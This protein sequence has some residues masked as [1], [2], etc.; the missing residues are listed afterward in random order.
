MVTSWKAEVGGSRVSGVEFEGGF[1]RVA[2]S[3]THKLYS[4]RV[5]LQ[6]DSRLISDNLLA[7][8]W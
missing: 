2:G 6:T 8:S 5:E 1:E 4:S 7:R 3:G